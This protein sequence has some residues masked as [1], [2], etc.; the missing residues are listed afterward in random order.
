MTEHK[1]AA[2]LLSSIP[3]FTELDTSV[4]DAVAGRAVRHT[5]DAGQ[6]VFLEGEA[7]AGLHI[8]E[9]GWLKSVKTSS[10]GREQVVRL[11][12]PG[13]TLNDVGAYA[14]VENQATVLAL[15]SSTV[16]VIS[17]RSM[18]ELMQSHVSLT[19]IIAR[20]MARRA[21]HL[22]GMVEDLSL[23]P[24]VARLA[25]ILLEHSTDGVMV[26]R[27]WSTQ[28]EIAARLGTVPDVAHRALHSLS[29]EGLIELERR[30]IRILDRAGLESKALN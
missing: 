13:E 12:G 4:L 27:S 6:V 3:A 30:E 2:A 5:Y 7:C 23:R 17:C 21:I 16:W 8:V 18:K 9:Q 29:R 11:A 14:G 22:M 26:R 15:E 19:H 10:A 1:Q 20:N 28:S 24:V 25:R